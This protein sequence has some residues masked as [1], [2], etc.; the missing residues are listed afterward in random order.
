MPSVLP[1]CILSEIAKEHV[2]DFNPTDLRAW[3]DEKSEGKPWQGKLYVATT[4][5]W[6]TSSFVQKGCAP[7]L[8]AGWWTLA[9]CKHNMLKQSPQWLGNLEYPRFIFVLASKDSQWERQALITVAKITGFTKSHEEYVRRVLADEDLRASRLSC[10]KQENPYRGHEFGDCHANFNGEIGAPVYGHLH[11]RKGKSR[12]S[13]WNDD[14]GTD[15]EKIPALLSKEFLVWKVALIVG[16]TVKGGDGGY[17]QPIVPKA[18]A[19]KDGLI[20]EDFLIDNTELCG[21]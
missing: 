11:H 18:S 3:L 6:D 15:K 10:E 7:N 14:V 16:N 4:I 12:E 9:C 21:K 20:F 8:F 13:L 5:T 17:G 1:K 19:V 2:C